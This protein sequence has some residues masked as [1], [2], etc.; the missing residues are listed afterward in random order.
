MFMSKRH[1]R[2]SVCA[3]PFEVLRGIWTWYTT[4]K[5]LKLDNLVILAGSGSRNRVRY[6]LASGTENLIH[7]WCSW[8]LRFRHKMKKKC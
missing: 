3:I 2:E 1:T 6:Y 5:I 4:R 7:F 8:C